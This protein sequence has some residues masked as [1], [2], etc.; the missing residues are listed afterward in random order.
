MPSLRAKQRRGFYP[1]AA[2][3]RVLRR[4]LRSLTWENPATAPEPPGLRPPRPSSSSRQVGYTV[5]PPDGYLSRQGRH[6]TSR[7][8]PG[9]TQADRR[10]ETR[11][12]RTRRH[13]T[14]P[15]R[16]GPAPREN[17]LPQGRPTT[18]GRV[19][20]DAT[21]HSIRRG[22][23]SPT[24]VTAPA[25][26]ATQSHETTRR[27][28]RTPTRTLPRTPTRTPAS[29]LGFHPAGSDTGKLVSDPPGVRPATEVPT[30]VY[31]CRRLVARPRRSHRLHPTGRYRLSPTPR[32][33]NRG[34]SSSSADRA[35][36]GAGEA[37]SAG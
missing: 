8:P 26:A 27:P 4:V 16:R 1:A 12:R 28:P 32:P 18:N 37:W 11:R 15:H 14:A 25:R 34:S 36:D 2:Y 17:P 23:S 21:A 19:A 13:C 3:S 22:P 29:D 24:T 31:R 33:R 20:T 6:S 30:P 10:S 7:T 5:W 35:A 9:P